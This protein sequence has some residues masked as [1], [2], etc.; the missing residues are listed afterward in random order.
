MKIRHSLV[1]LTVTTAVLAPELLAQTLQRPDFVNDIDSSSVQE[2]G[3]EINT[4]IFAFM[5]IIVAAFSVHPGYLFIVGRAE[6]GKERLTQ[7]LIGVVIA[8]LLGGVAFTVASR[9]Q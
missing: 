6:E 7:I 3:D 9:I 1:L 5:A 4:W 2:A 8:L